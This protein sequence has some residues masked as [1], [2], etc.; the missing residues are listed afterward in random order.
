MTSRQLGRYE[1]IA[2]L[3]KGAMGTVY[4]ATDPLLSRTVAIKTIN[5]SADQG[6]MAEYEARFYQE[7]KAAGGL[8]HP[9]I[10]TVYD[11]GRSGNV[12]YLA[13]ELLEGRELRTLMTQGALI[14]VAD[15]IDIAAQIAEGLA[16]AHQRGVVHRD[17]KPANI[18]IVSEG[19]AKIT[20]FGIAHMRSSQVRTQTG[21]MLGSPKY[22]SPEQVLGKRA[23]PGSDIFSLGVILYEMLTGRAPF[24]GADV[25]AI[26]FQIVNLVPPAPSSANPRVP[27]MLDFIV[28]KA[29]AKPLHDRY[30]NAQQLADDLRACRTQI[31]TVTQSAPLAAAQ[32][33]AF[34]KID[35]DAAT[36]ALAQSYPHT[37]QSDAEQATIDITATL[38][39]SK[40][41]DS[42]EATQRLAAQT[43]VA[44]QAKTQK[45]QLVEPGV[46]GVVVS[47]AFSGQI[48]PSFAHRK[49][50]WSKRDRLTF[51]VSVGAA[52]VGAVLIIFL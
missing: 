28:A 29:L 47:G 15:V 40:V 26:M 11:I 44:L 1:I 30:A 45:L 31:K 12:A 46:T 6:E 43:G 16:Y 51:G 3:G 22:M 48:A 42:A 36:Q 14:G 27:A 49:T 10:V 18:M 17:I 33:S 20:D 39:V 52:A 37:R 8:S 21:I 23:E 13:M 41:F 38:G 2:E 24:A 35:V 34:A 9:N 4:R 32:P 5:M 7:A 50:A 25:N 19:R